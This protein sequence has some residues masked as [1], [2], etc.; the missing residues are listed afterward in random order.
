MSV[1]NQLWEPV[2]LEQWA[3]TLRTPSM[4]RAHMECSGPHTLG[5]EFIRHVIEESIEVWYTH[6]TVRATLLKARLGPNSTMAWVLHELRLHQ[7]EK[8]EGVLREL[9]G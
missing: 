7:Q 1:C 3:A 8:R 2:V 4:Q 9:L 6:A 5:T